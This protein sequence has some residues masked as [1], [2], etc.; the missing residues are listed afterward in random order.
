MLEDNKINKM[1][2]YN[3]ISQE[4]IDKLVELY[5]QQEYIAYSHLHDSYDKFIEDV[6]NTIKNSSNT[7]FEI[8]EDNYLYRYKFTFEDISI[9]PPTNETNDEIIFPNQARVRNLTYS[10]K[11]VATVKQIQEKINVSTGEKREKIVGKPEYN[12][13]VAVVPMMV[14]SKYCSL[15]IKKGK[16]K[17][18]CKV[19][20]G[21]YFI[22]KGS[23]KVIVSQEERISNKP[24][25]F[26]SGQAYYAQIM[27][28]A[29]DLSKFQQPITIEIKEQNIIKIKVPI[30]EEIPVIILMKALGVETDKDIMDMIVNKDDI[31]MM[32]FMR[33]CLER[34]INTDEGKI[35]TK[36]QAKE[37]LINKIKILK[38]YTGNTEEEI[39]KQKKE[40]LEY[41][42]LNSFLIHIEKNKRKK[43]YYLGYMI[44]KLLKCYLGRTELDDRHSFL[45]KRIRLPGDLLFELFKLNY[46]KM[47]DECGKFFRKR[48][49]D[50][51]NPVNIIKQ[52][53]DT[54]I[55][56]KF[57]KALM[58]GE[59][60]Y[61]KGVAQNMERKNFVN[62]AATLRRVKSPTGGASDMK[63]TAPR[64]MHGSQV[65]FLCITGDSEI[66]LKNGEIKLMKELDN[67]DEIITLNT[68]NNEEK[69]SKFYN[70]FSKIPVDIIKIRTKSGRELKCDPEHPLLVKNDDNFE[71]KKAIDINEN[72]TL[73]IKHNIRYI[74]T[75]DIKKLKFNN[76]KTSEMNILKR[77]KIDKI[78][79]IDKMIYAR[80]IG[81]II[82]CSIVDIYRNTFNVY[83]NTFQ[84]VI[85]LVEDIKRITGKFNSLHTKKI[86]DKNEPFYGK[87]CVS[88]SSNLT[89]IIKIM[90]KDFFENK[91]VPS[92]IYNNSQV[93]QREFINGLISN[94]MENYKISLENHMGYS[95]ERSKNLMIGIKN[96]L[97]KFNINSK[98]NNKEIH[99]EE[100]LEDLNRYNDNFRAYYNKDKKNVNSIYVEYIK[101]LLNGHKEEFEYFKEKNYFTDD[102]M[103]VQVESKKYME[104]EKVYDFTTLSSNHNF[105]ANSIV[106]HN[107]YVE[108]PEGK[109]VGIVKS[110]S[111]IG[112]VTVTLP[113]QT[114]MIKSRVLEK[115]K[116]LNDINPNELYKYNKVFLNG[117]WI[118]VTEKA[119]ELVDYMKNL[120]EKNVI[121]PT[122][123]INHNIVSEIESDEIII[124]TDSGRVFR[125]VIR[126]KNNELQVTNNDI[127]NISLDKTKN[128]K[129]ITDWK[130]FLLKNPGKIEFIDQYDAYNSLIAMRQKDVIHNKEKQMNSIKQIKNY[131]IEDKNKIVNRYN[132]FM[133]IK[134]DYCEIDPA[135]LIGLTVSNSPFI[136][137]N[138][139]PR[140]M[141][142]YSQAKQAMGLY[143]S[144][145]RDRLDIS[146]I[147]FNSQ[148]PLANTKNTKYIGTDKLTAGE[149]VIVAIA[150]YTGYNQ[151]DSVIINNAENDRGL[152][153]IIEFQKKVSMIQKNQNTSQDDQFMKPD[154]NQVIGMKHGNY[155][156]LNEKGY[157]PEETKLF[158]NDVVLGKVSPIQPTGRDNKIFKDNSD[159]YKSNLPGHVD[160]VWT[161]IY[162]QDGYELRKARIRTEMKLYIGDKM[163]SRAGQKGTI[164]ITLKGVDMPFTKNGISPSLIMNPNAIPSRMTVG[165]LVEALVSKL[166]AVQGHEIDA[167]PFRDINIDEQREK[168]KKYGYDP[169]GYEYM[170]NGF[171]GEK[172]KTKIFICP[173]YYQ[174]LKH[175]VNNKIHCLTCDTQVLTDYGWKYH[176]EIDI[177]IH[178]VATIVDNNLEYHKPNKIFRYNYSGNVYHIKNNDIDIITT[179]NHRLYA[180]EYNPVESEW[181]NFTDHYSSELCNKVSRFRKN[182]INK[183]I[184]YKFT[185]TILNKEKYCNNDILKIYAF[186]VM[187][188]KLV[189]KNMIILPYDGEI[190]YL[191]KKYY[192]CDVDF[193]CIRVFSSEFIDEYKNYVSKLPEWTWKLNKMQSRIFMNYILKYC[194]Y[195][196]DDKKILYTYSIDIA[197]DFQRLS[198]HAENLYNKSIILNKENDTHLYKLES[199]EH[200]PIVKPDDYSIINNFEGK[201]FCLEMP[202]ETFYIRRKGKTCWTFNSRARGPTTNLTRQ[203][204]E[205]RARDGGLRFGETILPKSKCANI[206]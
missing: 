170:Y 157:A 28:R 76:I 206:C 120:K 21:G 197:N 161:G 62:T 107:C 49:T 105:F 59:W 154:E 4:N 79:N 169:D 29:N 80:I 54:T 177:N 51:V 144:N 125:P 38:S 200:K 139:G 43:A 195:N 10:S 168:L 98:L 90:N 148:K 172:M 203:P 14:K 2:K 20:P 85:K 83:L 142:Q 112:N 36:D 18:E 164:G 82:S 118:G 110:L 55:E 33:L 60:I 22:V 167:T 162:D 91:R 116:D 187:S 12:Y 61:E 153:R 111:M 46:K 204:P 52:I 63:L 81:L 24:L 93:I 181:N 41:L 124:Y 179:P 75:K 106:T 5:F 131:N 183:N 151:E 53:K 134:Y 192:M 89:N 56:M 35:I 26:K 64:H 145:Y 129:Y 65:G 45:N 27:S 31:E 156:K 99:I 58:T 101:C 11:I 95:K 150:C 57:N 163:C 74:S 165:Q 13:P 194:G 6:R 180:S 48:N 146:Y 19:D 141:Y 37:Y 25:V 201:I 196:D 39:K 143:V 102:K 71:W 159:F 23:E 123:S 92:W 50:N 173:T 94:G 160:K 174:R 8:F 119:K 191:L 175:M 97:E 188:N 3:M 158:N 88:L 108:T 128:D 15:N 185:D 176:D 122:T 66:L 7:F 16:D 32:N 78:K 138:Q 155:D 68:K 140:N 189:D 178:K 67:D 130:E 126:V 17:S 109:D 113:E 132:N 96:I 166:A 136:E 1:S 103:F 190:L 77:N 73:M 30:L 87:F 47:I 9:K 133:F 171:T 198:L 69:S 147:L 152:F 121:E 100:N 86:I 70:Y 199:C 202:Y 72:D 184:E 42:L 149:N 193:N 182:A 84:D 44:N 34:S 127:N 40:H 137:F 186:I 114:N 104:S 135:L 117:E 205:G 115:I